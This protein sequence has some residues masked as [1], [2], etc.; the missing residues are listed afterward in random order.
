MHTVMIMAGGLALL[1]A[2]ALAS[3]LAGLGVGAGAKAFIPLW[4]V[5][6]AINMWVG[7]NKAGYTYAQ[8]FPIFLAVFAIPAIVALIIWRMYQP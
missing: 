8:E 6:A 3:R 4:L 5:A 1:A 7:V 2:C